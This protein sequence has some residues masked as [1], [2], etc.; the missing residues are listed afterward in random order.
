MEGFTVSIAGQ[1]SWSVLG[2]PSGSNAVD[3]IL[4]VAIAAL[5]FTCD[6]RD[7]ETMSNGA[8]SVCERGRYLSIE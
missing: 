4:G 6:F 1:K 3:V 7:I 8:K 5:P 2:T